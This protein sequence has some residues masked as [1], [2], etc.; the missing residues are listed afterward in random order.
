ME[1]LK[2]KRLPR[3]A[4]QIDKAGVNEQEN[5]ITGGDIDRR[6]TQKDFCVEETALFSRGG[7]WRSH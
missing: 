6:N 5:N 3:S 1:L 2:G 7:E 4:K